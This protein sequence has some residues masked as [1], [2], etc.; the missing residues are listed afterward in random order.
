M[1]EEHRPVAAQKN[2]VEVV[3]H[4]GP[5]VVAAVEDQERIAAEE[6]P[7]GSL[8]LAVPVFGV[9]VLRSWSWSGICTR[10]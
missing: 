6:R 3:V 10:S 4:T 9:F 8:L 1:R 7:F 2:K 5:V